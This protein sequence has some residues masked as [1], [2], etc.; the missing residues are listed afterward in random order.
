MVVRYRFQKNEIVDC[1]RAD[2]GQYARMGLG[3]LAGMDAKRAREFSTKRAR[4]REA[5]ALFEQLRQ[6][7]PAAVRRLDDDRVMQRLH[8]YHL[9]PLAGQTLEHML[10]ETRKIMVPEGRERGGPRT[11]QDEYQAL[12]QDA[13]HLY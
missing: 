3:L 10:C 12:W 1:D 4:A 7:L 2:L 8:A 6:E 11:T 13:G 9:M 5:D